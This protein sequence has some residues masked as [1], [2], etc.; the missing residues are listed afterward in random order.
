MWS[1][2]S[3]RERERG[4]EGGYPTCPLTC[5]GAV[6]WWRPE[7]PHK[8]TSWVYG[9]QLTRLPVNCARATAAEFLMVAP[10]ISYANISNR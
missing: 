3:K 2:C 4:H 9:T 7:G 8:S 6:D 1:S 5:T 10:S